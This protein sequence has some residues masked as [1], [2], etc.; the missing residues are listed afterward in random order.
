MIKELT[1][2]CLRKVIKNDIIEGKV[3]REKSL[4]LV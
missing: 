3:Q 4:M 2:I 1:T